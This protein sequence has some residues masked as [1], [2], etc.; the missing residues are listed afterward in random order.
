M[1]S[2][3]LVFLSSC[4]DD[5][6][7]EVDPFVGEYVITNATI[8][9]ALSLSV[10]EQEEPLP[11]PAGIPITPMIQAALLGAIE[12]E[13]QNTFIELREDFS[14][15]FSCTTSM[16]GFDAGTWEE[17][18]ET[19]LVLYLNSTAVPP[20]GISLTVSDVS[21]VGNTLTGTSVVPVPEPMLAGIVAQY[22]PAGTWS[23][24]TEATPDYLPLSF[25]IELT[26]Q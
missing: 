8:S 2:V 18:S 7:P 15:Y 25:T 22:P 24:D 1:I 14:I 19:V 9:E 3:S 21:L 4:K 17:Q 6:E 23:L 12:C 13:A 10:N 26:K 5:E 16:E 20:L 11:I